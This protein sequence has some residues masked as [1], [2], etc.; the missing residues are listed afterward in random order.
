MPQALDGG[1]EGFGEG[2]LGAR[3]HRLVR[4][5]HVGMT[6]KLRGGEGLRGDQNPGGRVLREVLRAFLF[7]LDSTVFHLPHGDD[8][9]LCGEA[10]VGHDW[11]LTVHVVD[12]ARI[13]LPQAFLLGELLPKSVLG[14]LS[15]FNPP[16]HFALT[17]TQ[18]VFPLFLRIKLQHR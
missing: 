2:P 12:A 3:V 18:H 13:F 6:V 1:M 16:L 15:P 4:D 17:C 7:E 5:L 11:D 8:V 10:E 9:G 14:G